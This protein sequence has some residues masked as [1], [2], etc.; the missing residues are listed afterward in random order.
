MRIV[1]DCREVLRDLPKGSV[2]YFGV[3]QPVRM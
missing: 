2:P 1:G 3:K